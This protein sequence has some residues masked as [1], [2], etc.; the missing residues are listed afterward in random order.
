MLNYPFES[1]D[2]YTDVSTINNYNVAKKIMGE[3]KAL[4]LANYAS[5]DNARSVVQWNTEKNAGFTTADEPWFVVNPNYKEINVEAAEKD[6]DSILNFYRALLK[7]RKENEIVIYGDY[8]EHYKS[9]K[10]LYVYERNYEGKRMLVI[11]VFGDKP[12]KF[13]APKGFDLSKGKLVLA[14]YKD[15]DIQDNGFTTKPY[16]TRVYLFD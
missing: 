9:S 15:A 8:K 14:N 7:F 16:E 6:P 5:R 10:T 1:I 2:Q 4:N 13:K 11:N 12:V 3:E